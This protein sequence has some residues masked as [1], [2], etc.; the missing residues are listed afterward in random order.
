V[1]LAVLFIAAF[2]L[3]SFWIVRPFMFAFLWATLIVIPTWPLMERLCGYLG[4]R[5]GLAVGLVTVLLLLLVVIP[6]W[7][8]FSALLDHREVMATWVRSLSK[9]GFIAPPQWINDVP[10]IGPRL[11]ERWLEI[12]G[13]ERQELM[14]RIAPYLQSVLSW[15]ALQ[16]GGAGILFVHF[17]LTVILTALLFMRGEIFAHGALKFAHRLGGERGEQV[18]ILAGQAVRAVAMGVVVTALVQAA[19][20]AVA[21]WIVGIPYA[22]MLS[23]IVFI[24]AVVQI[25]AGPVLIPAVGWLFWSGDV[26]WGIVLTVFSVFILSIDNFL[27]PFLIQR[28]ADLPLLLIFA[29]VI[30]GLISFGISGLFIGPIVLAVSFTLLQAWVNED[31]SAGG[32]VGST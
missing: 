31:I 15:I 9:E 5:R 7:L 8:A 11:T 19:L 17:L 4:G 20:A 28:G 29:G 25:G 10:F 22:A 13:T 24:L 3:G 14:G 32:K 1:T 27:R 16:I 2:I 6:L 26:T 18:T 23:A 30:G 12:S 21:L